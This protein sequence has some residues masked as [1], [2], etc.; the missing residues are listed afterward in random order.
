MPRYIVERNFVDGL[1]I[2]A[3]AEGARTCLDVI[4]R[5]TDTGVSWVQSFVSAD[6]TQTY[7]IYDAPN[8][9]AVRVAAQKNGLPVTRITE[10]RVL[11]PYFHH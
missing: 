10:V 4:G 2:P 1:S 7:C 9:E 3:T 8:P 6:K 11:D 5:N